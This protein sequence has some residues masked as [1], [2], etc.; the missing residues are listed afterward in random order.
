MILNLFFILK[1]GYQF[2]SGENL[3][4]KEAHNI[5]IILVLQI[6]N[7]L[8]YLDAPENYLPFI[9]SD[10]FSINLVNE[11]SSKKDGAISMI[12][13]AFESIDL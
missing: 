10:V 8:G 2:L 1:N 5:E 12:N 4:E 7:T 9:K 11:M 13:E 6:L 3:S